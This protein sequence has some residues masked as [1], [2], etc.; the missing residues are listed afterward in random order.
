MFDSFHATIKMITGEEVL[1]RV[2]P[3]DENQNEIFI[4][5][6]P[7]IIQEETQ[8][9]PEKGV[10]ISGLIP[11]KWLMFANDET[12][13]VN[14]T[15]VVSMSELD[16]FGVDFYQKALIAAKAASP[17]KKRVESKN[18]SGYLGLIDKF[19]KDIEDVFNNSHDLPNT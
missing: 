13:I 4:L 6:N 9:N 15:H 11:K 3:T 7:I 8:V 1:A 12:T 17:I 18:N 16:K 10:A 19:R 5:K 14:K 2:L